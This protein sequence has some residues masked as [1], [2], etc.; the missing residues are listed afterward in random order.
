MPSNVSDILQGVSQALDTRENKKASWLLEEINE[1]QLVNSP[2]DHF[3]YLYLLSRFNHRIGQYTK[4]VGYIHKVD[5]I[6]NKY[7]DHI[8]NLA[9][10]EMRQL[11]AL[12][13]IT[14]NRPDEALDFTEDA[15]RFF[16]RAKDD[17]GVYKSLIN[18][19]QLLVLKGKLVEARSAVTSARKHANKNDNENIRLRQQ[20]RCNIA[21]S[22]IRLLSGDFKG[23]E[24]ESRA[25]LNSDY[26]SKLEFEK[27]HFLQVLGIFYTL[28]LNSDAAIKYLTESK[29]IFDSISMKRSVIV[30]EEYLALNDFYSGKPPEDVI[31]RY[32][33]ILD[34]NEIHPSAKAQTLRMLVET[35][36]ATGDIEA[37]KNTAQKASEAIDAIDEVIERGALHRAI[38]RINVFDS[39]REKAWS[40]FEESMKIL[41]KADANYELGLTYL[42][43]GEST[44]FKHEVQLEYLEKARKLFQDMGIM[45]RVEEIEKK[46]ITVYLPYSAIAV[47]NTFLDIVPKTAY[48]SVMKLEKLVYYAHAWTL[49]LYDKPLIDEEIQ[50]KPYGPA[51]E[52]II[53]KFASHGLDPIKEPF[54][55]SI[56]GSKVTPRISHDDPIKTHLRDIWY[57][58]GDYEDV[59]LSNL[60]Q[61]P[62]WPRR[63]VWNGRGPK[64]IS[65]QR[66][67]DYFMSLTHHDTA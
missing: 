66:I 57:V 45:P 5:N 27:A 54:R 33:D 46:I 49:A 31:K 67:K 44:F 26:L 38:A 13:N 58:Y 22:T 19:G 10:A 21:E 62:R 35:Y 17:N 64:V 53:K 34:D 60:S 9:Y 12:I 65:K 36:I 42:A 61:D 3:E 18:K 2:K 15:Y 20:L 11:Q 23:L 16:K 50:A 39:E 29:D 40:R 25:I 59:T 14:T 7:P 4:A 55:E 41:T 6:C 56:N 43:C 47:A 63:Q 51:I 8:T 28:T 48:I 1:S 24:E 52:S 32:R 30:S 37:A